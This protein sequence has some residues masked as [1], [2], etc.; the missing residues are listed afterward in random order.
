MIGTFSKHILLTGAGW[1][2]NWGGQVAN[3]VWQS[4]IGNAAVRG[5]PRLR[6]L[7]LREAS[8]EL[9]LGQTHLAPFTV[10]DRQ[11]LERALHD[12]FVS[13]NREIARPDHDPW[14][15]I[16]G[17]QEFL[18]RFWGQ[19]NQGN[20]TG[21]LFTLNQDLFFERNLYNEHAF[22]APG[23]ALPGL[24]P[25]YG[26]NWFSTNLGA[27][28]PDLEMRPVADPPREGHLRGQMNVIKLHGSFNWRSADGR[29]V[30]VVG[31]DKTAQIASL[32]LLSW[33]ADVFRRVVAA[34]MSG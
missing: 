26:Q 16:Y 25:V 32:P 22:G 11:E 31:T 17:V 33:Y 10:N 19:R 27:Y 8:F 4:L 23:G 24:A 5:N 2:K 29:N 28:S 12:T 34:G 18:F 7:L 1:S 15:N 14:I 9:A 30:L 13:I 6:D 21:Y 20:D 3:E